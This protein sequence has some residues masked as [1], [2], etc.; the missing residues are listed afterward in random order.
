MK[1][2]LRKSKRSSKEPPNES[3]QFDP[4]MD[5]LSPMDNLS[6]EERLILDALAKRKKS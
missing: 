3:E 6:L 1:K 2:N 4:N 5:D